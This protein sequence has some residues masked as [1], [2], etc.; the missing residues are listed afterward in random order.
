MRFDSYHPFLNLLFFVAVITF[1]VWWTHPGFLAISYVCS[2]IYSV[3]LRG[4]G[5]LL[6][7]IVLVP[8]AILWGLWFATHTHFGVT[9]LTRT[10]IGNSVTLESLTFGMVQGFM[11]ASVA[12][13]CSCV[14][15]L[16]TADK[17]VYLLGRVSPRLSLML[18]IV[19]R[20]IPVVKDRARRIGVAQRGIGAG[21]GQGNIFR[22][23]LHVGHQLA[24]LVTW[25]LDRFMEMGES[26]K[27]RGSR[28]RGRTAYSLYRFDNRDRALALFF[29]AL[30]T[31]C[32]VGAAF[33]Q[34]F[35]L[36]SPELVAPRLTVVSAV[37]FVAYAVLCMTP[38]ALQVAGELAFSR[39]I[40]RLGGDQHTH[41]A[42]RASNF[43]RE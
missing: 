35:M 7:N 39:Q 18:A 4:R 27:S 17:V 6:F 29:V 31:I 42:Q 36:Y 8:L 5:A 13:W 28:L 23:I 11:L 21:V 3:K 15:E 25:S 26:M 9:V 33:G 30:I 12:M 40:A 1:T 20:A 19:L 2:F 24:A 22:R 38:F 10:I 16:F 41:A 37:F 43:A 14:L 34:P 32:G